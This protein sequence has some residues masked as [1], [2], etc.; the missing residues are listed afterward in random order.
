MWCMLAIALYRGCSLSLVPSVTNGGTLSGCGVEY[1]SIYLS[2][3]STYSVMSIYMLCISIHQMCPCIAVPRRDT[4]IS[5][6]GYG[7]AAPQDM[8]HHPLAP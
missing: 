1:L 7:A 3:V 2:M 5:N 6:L 4:P 8:A